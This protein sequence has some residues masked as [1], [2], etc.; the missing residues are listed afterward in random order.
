MINSVFLETERLILK[1]PK[2]TDLH[3]LT[4]LRSDYKV[5][6]NTGYGVTQTNEEVKEY[7]NFAINYEEKHGMGFFL[8]FEKES[9]DFVG[10]AGLFHLLFDDTQSEI[11]VAYHLHKKFWSKGYATELTRTLVK[12]GFQHLSINRLVA[13]TYPDNIASQKALKKSGFD[14]RGKKDL[15]D[16]KEL[17]WYEIYKNDSIELVPYNQLWSEMAKTEIKKL[18]EILPN[19]YILDIQHI[20]STAIPGIISKPII[21]LQIAVD[22]LDDIKQ[23]AIDKLKEL[24]YVYWDDNPDKERMF[25]VK[26]MPPFGEKRT[27]HIHIF[28]SSSKHWQNKII[29]RDYLLTHTE[30]AHEYEKLKIKLARKY[31]YDREQYTEAKTTFVNAVL[32]NATV[33]KSFIAGT[34]FKF[35]KLTKEYFDILTTWFN[36]R[37][38]QEYYSLRSWKQKEVKVK[39]SKYLSNRSDVNAYIFSVDEVPIGYIQTYPIKNHPWPNQDF[40]EEII[41]NS[42]GIDFFIGETNYVGKG[43]GEIMLIE[44]LKQYIWPNNCYCVADPDIRNIHS[45]NLLKKLGFVKTKTISTT[46]AIGDLVELQLMIKKS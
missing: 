12:W 8:V 11:E 36:Q 42:A 22:S 7:L 29:F 34:K 38:V 31:L 44:F 39:L 10:E 26:G 21:D 20:G 15:A 13:S 46:N 27:H 24:D 45:I 3:N 43:F 4:V 5:M 18:Y 19:K 25:F 32:K 35:Y 14:F 41:D 6:Q 37:H 23:I 9:G 2:L 33:D 17:Y 30:S 40:T 1:T 16:G 28:E